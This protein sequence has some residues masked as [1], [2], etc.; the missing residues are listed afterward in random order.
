MRYLEIIKESIQHYI[1]AAM[2]NV[3]MFL[4]DVV[5]DPSDIEAIGEA[6]YTLAHDAATDLGANPEVASQVANQ[7][8]GYYS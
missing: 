6:A 4:G 1:D 8:K 7:V 5:D 3:E 2:E